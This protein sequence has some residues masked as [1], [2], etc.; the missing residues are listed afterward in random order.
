[1]YSH[2]PSLALIIQDTLAE[3]KSCAGI[4]SNRKVS[5]LMTGIFISFQKRQIINGIILTNT[6][7]APVD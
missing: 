2:D 1:L 5:K 6:G 4:I 7:V 3:I